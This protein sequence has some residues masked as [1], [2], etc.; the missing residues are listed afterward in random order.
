MTTSPSNDALAPE[1]AGP[2]HVEEAGS[3]PTVLLLHSS[4]LSGRQWRRLVPRL[5]QSGYRAV[6]PD[7]TG[8]G[9]SPEWLEPRPFSYRNDVEAI[10]AMLEEL[11]P[12]HL[13]GHS[14][15]GLVA[16]L[17]ALERP[18]LALSVTAYEPVAF[19]VLDPARDAD[20]LA[21][22]DGNA[23]RWGPTAEDREG[24][25]RAFV[26]YWNGKGAWDGLREDAKAEFRR[27][28]WAVHREVTTLLEDRTTAA[29]YAA[30]RC[31][32][33]LLHGET[34]PMSERRAVQ[35]LAEALPGARDPETGMLRLHAVRG[36]GHM[37]AL[38]HGDQVGA[39]IVEA[40]RRH[41]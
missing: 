24:W 15:G 27:V 14:F 2:L 32:V 34:S 16:L 36:A 11:G 29:D 19:G 25:L 23:F 3:G 28:A 39:I 9:A 26:E 22:L 33:H 17:V 12:A 37:G 38:T 40:L 8:H 21:E 10:G 18:R 5:V 13:V 31:P 7:L 30:L 4:G 35:R 41:R 6:V 1:P 20:A